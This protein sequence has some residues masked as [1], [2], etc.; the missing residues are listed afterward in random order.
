MRVVFLSLLLASASYTMTHSVLSGGTCL[1]GLHPQFQQDCPCLV[2]RWWCSLMVSGSRLLA[3]PSRETQTGPGLSSGSPWQIHS[4]NCSVCFFFS[5][6]HIH[7]EL[8]MYLQLNRQ[9]FR[10]DTDPRARPPITYQTSCHPVIEVYN[11]CSGAVLKP[12][13]QSWARCSLRPV[14]EFKSLS[15]SV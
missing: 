3:P 10:F 15:L 13:S 4:S 14:C 12:A 5:L 2:W 9:F 11:I 8:L 1:D 6:L 7:L